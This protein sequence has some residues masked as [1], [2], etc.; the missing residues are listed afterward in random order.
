MGILNV[1]PDSFHAGSRVSHREAALGM[2]RVMVTQGA[3]FLDIGGYSSRPGADDISIQEEM[4][5]VL[6]IVERIH[7]DF[8]HIPIS[9]DTFRSPVAAAALSAGA[10]IINDISGGVLDPEIMPL[11]AH[12]GAPY[13]LMHMQGTPADMQ[14][15]P[16]YKD[17]VVD[18]M[19]FFIAQ[20]AKAHEAGIHDVILD[21]GFGFGKTM[22]HNFQLLQSLHAFRILGL[23][24]LVGLSRKSMIWKI[25][26]VTPSEAL[27]GTTALHM[28]ALEQGAGILRVHDV[29]EAREVVRLW[30][31]MKEHNYAPKV[32]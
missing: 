1:T 8:P 10:S 18:I 16:F 5:R 15:S 12:Q 31:F 17:V 14:R 13:V 29:K 4:D 6:P 28:V 21:P 30:E 3:D 20:S 2:A 24:M 22:A 7:A 11:A 19:D 9:I 26:N 27:N 23:P 25:L 32:D